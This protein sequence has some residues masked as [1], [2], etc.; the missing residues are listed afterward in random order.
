MNNAVIANVVKPTTL[1]E[2]AGFTAMAKVQKAK[3]MGFNVAPIDTIKKFSRRLKGRK[4]EFAFSNL[5]DYQPNGD[6]VIPTQELNKVIKAQHSGLFDKLLVVGTRALRLKRANPD[7]LVIGLI[8]SEELK[9]TVE[10][11]GFFLRREVINQ[12]WFLIAA[13]K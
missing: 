10:Q 6:E 9:K 4:Q 3:A 11:R 7:P 8:L 13:W 5:G 12:P 1:L 2:A